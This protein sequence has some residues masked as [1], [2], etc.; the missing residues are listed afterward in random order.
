MPAF[1]GRHLLAVLILL[2]LYI[3]AMPPSTLPHNE[4]PFLASDSAGF[5]AL[6]TDS[7][8]SKFD[9][10]MSGFYPID[11]NSD[12][13]AWR[14][15]LIDRATHT[16]DIQY[17]LW[18]GDEA[19]FL[20]AERLLR[21]ADRGV[22]VRVLI[23]DLLLIGNDDDLIALNQHP[24]MEVRAFNPWARRKGYLRRG[25]EFLGAVERL[26]QRM[27]NKLMVVDSSMVIMGGRN[28][29]NAY[30]GLGT[31][32]NFRDFDVLGVG[33]VAHDVAESFEVYWQN[34]RSVSP[35]ELTKRKSR[36]NELERLRTLVKKRM[37]HPILRKNLASFPLEEQTW[38]EMFHQLEA[39][40]SS[41]TVEVIYDDPAVMGEAAADQVAIELRTLAEAAQEELLIAVAYIIP[42]QRFMDLIQ[43]ATNRGV[44][45]R[46]L[47]NSLASHDVPVANSGYKH[48]RRPLLEA[49]AELY[50][51]RHDAAIKPLYDTE[52][53]SA[54]FMGYHVKTIV[55]DRRLSFVGAMNL[56]PRS[57]Y[58]NTENGLLIENPV[59]GDS[60]ATLIER[61]LE[62]ENAWQVLL[63]E[64]NKVYWTNSDDTVRRQPARNSWIR[65]QDWFYDLLPIK[66]QL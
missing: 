3:A 4:R 32:Y 15:A 16:I 21:A 26:N 51:V 42:T 30:F 54:Q 40:A 1:P 24:N 59:F 60:L 2:L 11:L 28:I 12:G 22:H 41:G 62:P 33:P 20:L 29:G 31:K 9:E 45:V 50:E 65:M 5:L 23:D 57:V 47:T 44:R 7:I 39:S 64:K 36:G 55:A 38:S 34:E 61:D 58:I 14:L 43:A 25:L 37:E 56:D 49:G 17:Y 19:G 8:V 6:T 66:S 13:L 27:H 35:D 46:I 52:P 18:Y 10:G 48:Y 53:H 63:N